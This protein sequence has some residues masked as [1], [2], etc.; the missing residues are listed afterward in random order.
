MVLLHG[1]KQSLIRLAIIFHDIHKRFNPNDDATPSG[2]LRKITQSSTVAAYQ[3]D[4]ETHA[5]KVEGLPE[6]FLLELFIS[7]LREDIQQEFLKFKPPDIQETM[8]LAKAVEAQIGG[9]SSKYLEVPKKFNSRSSLTYKKPSQNLHIKP[10]T[11]EGTQISL[12]RINF[13]ISRS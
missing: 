5:N 8:V 10:T 6:W 1:V 7:R 13:L 11:V 2:K 4:Y 3:A 12:H 9:T